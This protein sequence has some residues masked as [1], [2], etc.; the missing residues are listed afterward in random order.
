M[1]IDSKHKTT[2]EAKMPDNPG[3][4]A[5]QPLKLIPKRPINTSINQCQE[6][7]EPRMLRNLKA[8]LINTEIATSIATV[9]KMLIS[10][11]K[12][13]KPEDGI[14]KGSDLFDLV[15][16]HGLGEDAFTDT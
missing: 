12:V 3:A 15:V 7:Q 13:P 11:K 8:L 16:K 9:W 14:K 4:V 6:Y 5:P 1:H 2:V 10:D